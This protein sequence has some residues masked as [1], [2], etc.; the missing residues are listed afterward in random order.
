[1]LMLT[2]LPYPFTPKPMGSNSNA[3]AFLKAYMCNLD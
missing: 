3:S 1:L 2:A